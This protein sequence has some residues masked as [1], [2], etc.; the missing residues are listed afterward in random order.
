LLSVLLVVTMSSWWFQIRRPLLA[1]AF[2]AVTL[3]G[4]TALNEPQFSALVMADWG[5]HG[6][7]PYT[8]PGELA[9]AEGIAS[10]IKTWA[11]VYFV[12]GFRYDERILGHRQFFHSDARANTCGCR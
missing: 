4:T 12:A 3:V 5:G 7:A 6:T 1:I 8:T 9:V 10:L 11:G 2:A